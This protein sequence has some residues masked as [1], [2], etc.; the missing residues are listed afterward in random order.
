MIDN[1]GR[2]LLFNGFFVSE[3]LPIITIHVT[4]DLNRT[5]AHAWI[6]AVEHENNIHV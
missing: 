4:S 2:W 5:C 6:T 1:F 3:G